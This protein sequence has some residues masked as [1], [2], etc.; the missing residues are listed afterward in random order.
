M[1]T[2]ERGFAA[3]LLKPELGQDAAAALWSSI[4]RCSRATRTTVIGPTIDGL[5]VK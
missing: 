1:D 4:R 3:G 5:F 2:F